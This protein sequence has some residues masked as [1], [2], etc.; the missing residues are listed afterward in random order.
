LVSRGLVPVRAA[1]AALETA[2]GLGLLLVRPLHLVLHGLQVDHLPGALI[3][4]PLLLLRDV[5]DGVGV[6]LPFF[7]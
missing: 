6:R 2:F 1:V 5:V 3:A 7:V 4:P